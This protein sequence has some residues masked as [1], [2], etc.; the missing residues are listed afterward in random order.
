MKR[1]RILLRVSSNHQLDADGD[2]TIQRR[3]VLEYILKH[4]DWRLD[5]KEYFEGGVS[6]YRNSIADRDALQEAYKDAKN[7]EYDILVVYKDDRLGRRMWEIGGYIMALK[8]EG[9]D[10]YTTKDGCISPESSDI[11]GQMMLAL[12]YGHAQ[13]SSSDTGLR[14]KDTAIKLVEQGKFMGG[15]APY[16]YE[17]QPSGEISKHGRVLHKLV[18]VPEQAEVVKY[19]YYLSLNKEYG[20]AKIARTLNEDENYKNLAPNEFWKSGTITS[21]LTNPI[22]AGHTAYKR[23]E[24]INGQYHRLDSKDWVKATVPNEDIT[25]ISGDIWDRTQEK[26]MQRG[27]KYMKT[28]EHQEGVTVIKR[29]DGMLALID[30]TYCGYCGSK[31]VNGSQYNYWKIKDTGEKRA[32]KIAI[33]KCQSAWQG[34]PHPKFKAIRADVLEPMIFSAIAERI[35]I[36]MKNEDRFKILE[37]NQY[38]EKKVKEAELKCEKQELDNISKQISVMESKIPEAIMGDYPLSLEELVDSINKQKDAL[39]EQRKVVAQKEAEIKNI[40]ISLSEWEELIEKMPTWQDVFMNADTHTKRVL[41]NKLVARIDVTAD[42]VV[43]RFKLNLNDFLPKPR[44]SDD[45]DTIPYTP[46]SR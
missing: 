19:I 21:I 32:K 30:V 22:Y 37:E 39:D 10:I 36:L 2:L 20:S 26:R 5:G 16:G 7:K 45:S 8:Q 18:I 40:A 34:V 3:L 38:K 31:F 12:R 41:V 24:R 43:V 11:M 27:A 28:L 33:Y 1:V 13:K 44:I 14:V 23:R 6:G 9:V 15:S 25:I 4:D 46:C 42:M 35:G 29:N 17:F